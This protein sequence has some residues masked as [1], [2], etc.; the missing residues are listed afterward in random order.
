[1]IYTNSTEPLV[2]WL[3]DTWWR[4][5][6]TPLDLDMCMFVIQASRAVQSVEARSM[7]N[8][9][10]CGFDSLRGRFLFL[11]FC[12]CRKRESVVFAK[13]NRLSLASFGILPKTILYCY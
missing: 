11:F 3:Y 9:P 10:D 1:M 13:K 4:T 5:D 2:L 7:F 6:P 8:A 12:C